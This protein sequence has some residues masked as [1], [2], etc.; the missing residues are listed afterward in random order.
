MKKADWI[1]AILVMGMGL[2]CMLV[3]ANFFRIDFFR[4]IK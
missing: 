4:S 3:S 1:I 2:M